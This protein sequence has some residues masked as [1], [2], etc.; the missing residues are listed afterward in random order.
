MSISG[1]EQF[2]PKCKVCDKPSQ[3][4]QFGLCPEDVKCMCSKCGE[5]INEKFIDKNR[6]SVNCFKCYILSRLEYMRKMNLNYGKGCTESKELIDYFEK[7]VIEVR[8]IYESK[9]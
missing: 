3:Y 8:K 9:I 7:T 4:L 1:D 2:A 6:D 5:H